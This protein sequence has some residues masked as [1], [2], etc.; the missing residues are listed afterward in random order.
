MIYITIRICRGITTDPY[1]KYNNGYIISHNQ[2]NQRNQRNQRNMNIKLSPTYT[3]LNNQEPTTNKITS[4][5]REVDLSLPSIRAPDPSFPII[6]TQPNPVNL[7]SWKIKYIGGDDLMHTD[8]IQEYMANEIPKNRILPSSFDI[9]G[10]KFNT[11]CN[12]ETSMPYKPW[13]F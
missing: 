13:P 7:H 6:P 11:P 10:S 5:N 4:S 2:H 3:V 1:Y 12:A 8:C 9:T